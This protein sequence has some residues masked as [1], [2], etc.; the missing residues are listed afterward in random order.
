MGQKPSTIGLRHA[1]RFNHADSIIGSLVTEM[2]DD[3]VD[4][5]TTVDSARAIVSH[6]LLGS[7]VATVAIVGA[8][9]AD[10][11][12]KTALPAEYEKICQVAGMVGFVLPGSDTCVKI[13]GFATGQ[14]EAGNL[15]TGYLWT[16][17]GVALSSTPADQRPAFG[18]TAREF[19][20]WTL[21]RTRH[22][23]RCGGFSF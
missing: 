4:I 22:T 16:T 12:A 23:A 20:T 19:L 3:L 14:I 8:R 2:P 11:P 1:V 10:L 6:V 5:Q 13:S 7:V 15:K 17:Q 21:G 18:Y 9:A